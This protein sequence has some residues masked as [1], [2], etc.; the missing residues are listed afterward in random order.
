MA[1][2]KTWRWFGANDPAKHADL[3]QMGVEGIVTLEDVVEEIVGEPV[4]HEGLSH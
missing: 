2:Q 3:R 4:G 1:M